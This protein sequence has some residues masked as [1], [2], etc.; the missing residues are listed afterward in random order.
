M[1]VSQFVAGWT[2]SPRPRYRCECGFPCFSEG[3]ESY[4]RDGMCLAIR[5]VLNVM[6]ARE[7]CGIENHVGL[8]VNGIVL[9]QRLS[10]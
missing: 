5:R 4:H 1:S 8:D 6:S 9:Q 2:S 7:R 10:L 3:Q